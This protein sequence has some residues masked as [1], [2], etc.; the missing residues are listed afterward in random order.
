MALSP[1]TQA[2]IDRLKAE[3]DLIRNS[4]TNSVRS[5][6]IQLDKFESIFNTISAN[7]IEQTRILQMQ[8]GLAQEA[9]ERAKTQEQFDE[10][11]AEESKKYSEEK[12]KSSDKKDDDNIKKIGDKIEKAFSARS[13][14]GTMKDLAIAGAG[15]FVAYNFLKG[16]VDEATG[17]SWSNMEQSMAN[18]D[19]NALAQ[20]ASDTVSSVTNIVGLA[21]PIVTTLSEINWE[22][23]KNAVNSM[24]DA[25]ANFDDWL[26]TLPGIILGGTLFRQGIRGMVQGALDTRN[27]PRVGAAPQTPG[28]RGLGALRNTVLGAVT[29]L[30]WMYGDEVVSYL[31]DE[32]GV[33]QNIAEVGV[34]AATMGLTFATGV[35]TLAT[36]F[37]VTV[38]A[39]GLLLAAAVGVGL[40]LGKGIYDWY[41]ETKRDAAAA[42][43]REMEAMTAQE[44]IDFAT[45][46]PTG[47]VDLTA[48]PGLG[49]LNGTEVAVLGGQAVAQ[50]ELNDIVT[51]YR[52]NLDNAVM[53]EGMLEWIERMVDMLDDEDSRPEQ[54]QYAREQLQRLR[55]MFPAIQADLDALSGMGANDARSYFRDNIL[56]LY[57]SYAEDFSF[58]MG[59][60]GFRDFGAGTFSI[61]HGRE[62]VVPINTAAGRFLDQYFTEN[63]E[64]K[65]ANATNLATIASG[66]GGNSTMNVIQPVNI[67][68]S[69]ITMADGGKSVSM[70]NVGGGGSTTPGGSMLPYGLTGA[71]S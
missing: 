25:V 5:V 14:L 27:G 58:R 41:Q 16:A 55:G 35:A 44:G 8:A 60:K 71:F 11:K 33:P 39:P 67:G 36:I 46:G 2:I 70:I 66:A 56:D 24:I 12:D 54:R 64:P 37:G 38:G 19:W 3:G 7:V 47:G 50:G 9:V 6:K 28:Q 63:W 31:T 59:T 34:D 23:L 18:T 40:V 52:A 10:L 4:G 21:E 20:S 1:E 61:L 13:I 26:V 42:A 68:G 51:A 65:F 15:L 22:G 69:T 53:Q 32:V 45:G 43:R 62:A 48:I 30:A 17:G 29:T 49:A 57:N